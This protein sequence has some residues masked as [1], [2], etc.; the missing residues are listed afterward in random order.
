MLA[1]A[2]IVNE[3]VVL[4]EVTVTVIVEIVVL[5]EVVL[6]DV[7]DVF[8]GFTEDGKVPIIQSL[9]QFAEKAKVSSSNGR[10]IEEEI[11]RIKFIE[12]CSIL[13]RLKGQSIK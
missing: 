10:K 3:V 7:A 13:C 12:N 6:L 11:L 2:V 5:V 8:V 4:V 1:V 9:F